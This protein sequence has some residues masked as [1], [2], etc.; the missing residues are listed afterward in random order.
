M[1]PPP[2]PAPA[3]ALSACAPPLPALPPA[4]RT[5][6]LAEA[7][8]I[9]AIAAETGRPVTLASDP[10]AALFPGPAWW[11]A[12][13]GRLRTE[14]PDQ[15][16]TALLDGADATGAVMA[17]LRAGVADIAYDGPTETARRLADMARQTGSRLHRPPARVLDLRGT[18]PARTTLRAWLAG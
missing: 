8:M 17:A 4:V 7:R 3:R 1:L 6:S 15:P 2:D 14:V 13:V 18:N 11:A 10:G 9:L 16:F 5:R 12:L